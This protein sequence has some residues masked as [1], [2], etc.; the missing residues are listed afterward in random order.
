VRALDALLLAV[1]KAL[2]GAWILHLGFTHVSDDDYARTVIAE[3]F[4]H[5]PK[6]DPSGTSWLPLPFWVEG[7]AMMVF[8]RGLGTA[9]GVAVVLGA[10]GVVPVYLAMRAAGVAR[11][12]AVAATV[13]GMIAPWSAWLDVAT[14][15][16]GWAG[17]LVAA[18]AIGLTRPGARAWAGLGLLAASLSRYEAWPVC[19]VFAL[20]ALLSS[21]QKGLLPAA[22]ALAGPALWM[23]WN[24]HAHDGPL[25]FLARVTTFRQATTMGAASSM[26]KLLE[27][28]RAL[29]A[30]AGPLLLLGAFGVAAGARDAS[31]R[32]IW[33]LAGL[34]LLVMLAVLVY[35]SLRDAAPT[36]HPERALVAVG[37]VAAGAAAD[38]LG[39]AAVGFL[40]ASPAG[41]RPWIVAALGAGAALF[42]SFLARDWPEYPG[43]GRA[44]RRLVQTARGLAYREQD[45]GAL[46]VTPCEFEHFALIAT[47]GAPERV[48]VAPASHEAL[49]EDCPHVVVR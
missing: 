30:E 25:H 24:A 44:E 49:N 6:L 48:N 8:G 23:V 43:R 22:L 19:A 26:E 33:G 36:H 2:V 18:A 31:F 17:A 34:P 15:P 16:E 28:P 38:G 35:G 37:W 3:Q 29:V 20:V 40:G 21:R 41:A 11:R 14:V 39:R 5:A 46:A 47:F 12:S 32:K 10:L 4:A 7:A 45:A 27:Y 13:L 9:R 1:A 42:A